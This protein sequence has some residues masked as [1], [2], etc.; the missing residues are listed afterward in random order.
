MSTQYVPQLCF[1]S[2]SIIKK[3][4]P[5]LFLLSNLLFVKKSSGL[6][7]S[8]KSAS[9]NLRD[10][11]DIWNASQLSRL[12][13]GDPLLETVIMSPSL[14][15]SVLITGSSRGIGLQLVKELA[16]SSNR[17]A[18]IIA[19]ARNPS[20]STVI[21]STFGTWTQRV[22]KCSSNAREPRC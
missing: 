8:L 1:F 7:V 5:Q 4:I 11:V 20:G 21:T 2:Q 16:K 9:S 19:T 12:S 3:N 15:K 14:C 17:P 6:R 13:R 18:T 22:F 10:Y